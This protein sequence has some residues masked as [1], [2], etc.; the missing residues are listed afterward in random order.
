MGAGVGEATALVVD[1]AEDAAVALATLPASGTG[2]GL[3]TQAGTARTA[4]NTR[5]GRSFGMLG[6][7]TLQQA[8]GFAHFGNVAE[9]ASGCARFRAEMQPPAARTRMSRAS[10]NGERYR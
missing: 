4:A 6:E 2:G 5:T 10:T 8:P 3:F 1:G 9:L 7:D